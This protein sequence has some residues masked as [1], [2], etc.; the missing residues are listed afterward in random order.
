MC[1]KIIMDCLSSKGGYS[2]DCQ[3]QL[4]GVFQQGGCSTGVFSARG[5]ILQTVR[6]R[7]KR[8][9]FP[10]RSLTVILVSKA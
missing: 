6:C 8:G 7:I 5:V 3:N 2:T 1:V 9:I 4:Y 10:T